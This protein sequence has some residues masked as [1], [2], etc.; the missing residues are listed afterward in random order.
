MWLFFY[1]LILTYKYGGMSKDYHGHKG[2]RRG[3]HVCDPEYT[4]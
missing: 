2:L 4:W 1:G 3:G